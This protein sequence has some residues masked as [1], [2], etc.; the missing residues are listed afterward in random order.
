MVLGIDVSGE[1]VE[2]GNRLRSRRSGD[3][4]YAQLDSLTGG[5]YAE[6]AA[7]SEQAACLKTN[8][9]SHEQAAAVPLAA[10][11]ALTN[12]KHLKR[13]LPKTV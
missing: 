13:R 2:V 8:N 3:H 4:I 1:V 5:A 11:T 12:D 7:V 6:Y 10:L 9:M